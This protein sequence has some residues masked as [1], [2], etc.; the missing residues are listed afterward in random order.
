MAVAVHVRIN[1]RRH[2]AGQIQ[3]VFPAEIEQ[4]RLQHDDADD[5]AMADE[6]VGHHGLHEQGEH[7]GAEHLRQGDDVQLLEVLQHLVVV[8]AQNRLH[9][10]ADQHGEGE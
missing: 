4:D 7:R 10:H 8:I 3:R 6:F 1:V 5:D 9:E 2:C